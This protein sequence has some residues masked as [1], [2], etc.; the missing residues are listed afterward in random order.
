MCCKW[1]RARC[2]FV[3]CVVSLSVLCLLALAFCDVQKVSTA[4]MMPIIMPDDY[5]CSEA[6]TFCFREPK[7]GDVVVFQ[8]DAVPR[9]ARPRRYMARVIGVPGDR[10]RLASQYVVVNDQLFP[11]PEGLG[12]ITAC[13]VATNG[14]VQPVLKDKEDAEMQLLG[15]SEYFVVGDNMARS[16]DSRQWGVLPRRNIRGRAIWLNRSLV[17]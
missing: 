8:S 11:L 12:S 6:V 4:S 9:I 13:Q 16:I 10:V 7:R 2:L 5:V 1:S 15:T 3:T 17:K 14:V